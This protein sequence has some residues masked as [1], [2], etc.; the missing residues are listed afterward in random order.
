MNCQNNVV[1]GVLS[2]ILVGVLLG[3]GTSQYAQLVSFNSNNPDQA[4]TM[5]DPRDNAEVYRSRSTIGTYFGLFRTKDAD[6]TL[7]SSA[8]E[9][10]DV[11]RCRNAQGERFERCVNSYRV[12]SLYRFRHIA[13]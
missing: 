4:K 10:A 13:E 12:G 6:S 8:P 3:A 1:L 9:R 7:R 11:D 2:G 5:E